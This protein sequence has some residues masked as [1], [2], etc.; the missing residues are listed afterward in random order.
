MRRE[1][2]LLRLGKWFG[3]KVAKEY[4]VELGDVAIETEVGAPRGHGTA[5]WDP[6][7][8]RVDRHAGD[9]WRRGRLDVLLKG[10]DDGRPFEVVL[11]VKNTGWDAVAGR[12]VSPTLGRHRRQVWGYLEP[13]LER[14]DAGEVAWVQAALV[15]PHRPSRPGLREQIEASLGDYSITVLWYEDL[16]RELAGG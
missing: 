5:R 13:K 11:E 15:Y 6:S 7:G 2:D 3:A 16:E 4:G 12:R 9:P 10:H 1:P 14:V 8:V